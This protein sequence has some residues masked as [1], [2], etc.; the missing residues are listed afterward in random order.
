MTEAEKDMI[1]INTIRKYSRI[2]DIMIS[3]YVPCAESTNDAM[4]RLRDEF[5]RSSN[6]KSRDVMLD[7]TY[8]IELVMLKL[9]SCDGIPVNGVVFFVGNIADDEAN[10]NMVMYAIEPSK[11]IKSFAYHRESSFYIDDDIFE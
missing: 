10:R 11:S 8:G 4:S 9:R 2:G 7:V 1:D 3:V 6:I 5:S